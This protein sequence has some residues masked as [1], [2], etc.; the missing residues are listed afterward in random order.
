MV[1]Y[2]FNHHDQFVMLPQP[3][4]LIP[5]I[6]RKLLFVEKDA[7]VFHQNDQTRGLFVVTDG[8]IVM[9]RFTQA[10]HQVIIHRA[11]SGETF[12]EASLFS[13]HYHCDAVATVE[14]KLVELDRNFLLEKFVTE[15]EFALAIAKRF[16]QQNQAYRRKLEII[17]IKNAE[18]RIFA[19]MQEGLLE[20]NIRAFAAQIGLTHETVYRGLRKLVDK[21]ILLKGSRGNYTIVPR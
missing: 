19:A 9:R 5:K 10:G 1:E 6:A 14:S 2:D 7:V 12:A 4:N 21:N 11:K 18:E 16:A 20:E 3:F 8:H 15:P 13:E 17:C